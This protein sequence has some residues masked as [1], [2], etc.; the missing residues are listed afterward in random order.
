MAVLSQTHG[1]EAIFGIMSKTK[2]RS[3]LYRLIE[4]GQLTHKALLVP[5][6]ERGLEPGDDAVLFMLHDKLGAQEEALAE[7]IGITF[8]ALMPRLERLIERDLIARQA[9]G[10][11]LSPGLALTERGERIRE[12]L[13][14]AWSELEEALLGELGPKQRKKLG[15]QLGRFVELLRSL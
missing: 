6:V 9:T 11:D 10:P 3:T 4:A 2:S 8:E 5:L 7:E 14:H 13:A 15:R 1:D 12:V